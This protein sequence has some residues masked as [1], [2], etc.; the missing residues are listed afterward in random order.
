MAGSERTRRGFLG[1]AAAVAGTSGC[2]RLA[3]DDEQSPDPQA[4]TPDPSATDRGTERPPPGRTDTAAATGDPPAGVDGAWRQFNHDAANTG[5]AQGVTGPTSGV[6]ELW[7][8]SVDGEFGHD[9][10]TLADGAVYVKCSELES[11]LAY[12]ATSGEERWRTRVGPVRGAASPTVVDGTVYVGTAEGTVTALSAADGRR[13]DRF[14]ANAGE[15]NYGVM[16]SVTE[17]DGRLFFGD[18]SGV[19]Y[20]LDGDLTERWRVRTDGSI[21][22][23][24]PAVVEGT[25]YVGSMDGGLY[26]LNAATGAQEWRTSLGDAVFTAPA[27]DGETV[28]ATSITATD[29]G[30][31][32]TNPDGDDIRSARET[33]GGVHA[34]SAADGSVRWTVDVE[35]QINGEPA[36][37]DGTVVVGPRDGPV[38]AFDAA[39][40]EQRWFF[41][42][43]HVQE[44][45]PAVADGVAYLA[46]DR[47]YA[48][49]LASGTE[50]WSYEPANGMDT[51]PVVA[52]GIV[53]AGDHDG[54]LY[55]LAGAA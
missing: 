12:D 23:S 16:C 48:V 18:D 21:G 29:D 1:V 55:A 41:P 30:G 35:D 20:S 52:A 47:V 3:A 51:S 7:V 19:V 33:R 34:L 39:S 42:V 31:P 53:V 17:R 37:A 36:V 26:A 50:L 27:V 10:A 22:R 28:Y 2:L 9:S 44:G 40:G 15:R 49:D 13:L 5:H 46:S 43:G 25:V 14:E 24:T 45:S 6:R 38:Y 54:Y 8:A 11:V 4:V 32:L